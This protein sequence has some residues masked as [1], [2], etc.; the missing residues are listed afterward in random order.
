MELL[1]KQLPD[2]HKTIAT[3]LSFAVIPIS[4]LATDI[5]LPSMPNMAASLHLPESRIQLTLSFF[6]ISYG[7]TQFFA[8]AIVDALGRYQVSL[9]SLLLFVGSFWI[10]AQTKNIEV[11]Y[12]MRI[13][14]GILSGFAIVAKRA[15]FVDVYEGDE[16]RHYLSIMTIVWSLGPIIAPF[17]GGYLQVHFGW[18]SNF[19]ALAVYCGLLVV[20]EL[21]FSGETI[22]SRNPLQVHFLL[23]QY[24][25]MLQ[26]PD[27][28]YGML[29]CGLSYSLIM[30]YNLS[31]PFII[32][33]K[34]GYGA[35]TTG[36]ISLLMGLAW[37]S[38]G[39][40][41]RALIRRPLLPKLGFALIL[42][43]F[44][45]VCMFVSSYAISNLFSLAIFAFLIH[46]TAGFVFNN[47]FAYCIGR[48]PQAAGLAGGLTGGVAFVLTSLLSYGI[49]RVIGPVSQ[50]GIAVS[51]GILSVLAI[52]VIQL[53]KK[54]SGGVQY[55]LLY[56]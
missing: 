30:L 32:E 6:L 56:R 48:F 2:T 40:L 39:F 29:M 42:Q 43:L 22:R 23:R 54:R 15:Y 31:G 33:H 13:V 25:E 45:V 34:L 19:I 21:L 35:V 11:I 7:C 36:Y 26:T 55:G 8:G 20:L 9:M 46:L 16:R 18:Q 3:I 50:Q 44:L 1:N 17:L 28:F 52:L 41:G 47:Y 37:M 51:Y 53:V 10:T 24:R 38:G 27:F 14:Q 5:Y 4:G 49:V 12:L